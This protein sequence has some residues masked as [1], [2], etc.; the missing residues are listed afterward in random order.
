MLDFSLV[1]VAL[2]YRPEKELRNGQRFIAWRACHL[3]TRAE[4]ALV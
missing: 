1:T 3:R 2:P 4:S